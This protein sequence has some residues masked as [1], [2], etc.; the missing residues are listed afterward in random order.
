M[1]D[2]KLDYDVPHPIGRATASRRSLRVAVATGVLLACVATTIPSI[3]AAVPEPAPVVGV[4]GTA[5]PSAAPPEKCGT[6][7]R[8]ETALQG[9]VPWAD[10]LSGRAAEGYNCNLEIVGEFASAS[11]ANFDSYRTCVYYTDNEGG[12]GMAEGGGVVLDVSDPANPVKTDYLTARAMGNGG[13]SLRVNQKRGLL[14]TNHYNTAQ[15]SGDSD[16][17]RALAVYDLKKD[18]RH[19]ELLADVIM[20]A[21]EGHE[22]C[23][24]P[25]GNVYY[26][27]S[28]GTITPIDLTN[29][30]KPRQLSDPW[31]LPIHGCSISDDGKRGYLASMSGTLVAAA[32]A[33]DAAKCPGMLVVDTSA[34]QQLQRNAEFKIISCFATPDAVVQQST[35]PLRYG[36]RPYLFDWSEAVDIPTSPC[37]S[38]T[39]NFGYGWFVDISDEKN[40]YEVSKLQTEVML[41]QH[42]ATVA[43]DR[44]PQ[45]QGHTHGDAFWGFGSIAFTYDMHYCRPDRLHNPTILGCANFGSGL[46]VFDIRNPRAPQE[47]AYYNTGTAGPTHPALDFAVAP[48]VIRRDLGMIFWVTLNG[49][50]HAAK[51]REGVWPFKGDDRCPSSSD[52][53]AKQYDTGFAACRAA[54]ERRGGTA[55]Q[56]KPASAQ[57]SSSADGDS[58]PAQVA[59]PSTRRDSATGAGAA[60]AKPSASVTQDLATTGVGTPLGWLVS[61]ALLMVSAGLLLR[62]RAARAKR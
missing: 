59:A 35:Y 7:D 48:P 25:D 1:L 49:G 54:A 28:I 6:G 11:F 61:T 34:V 30:R 37:P 9:Q 26:M 36:N 18:C 22:G 38:S 51:F 15:T 55:A 56:R 2:D 4:T 44:G 20:P 29:P 47:I 53:F 21:A 27:A 50:F 16:V 41:P 14:V 45:T 42:C 17:V 60:S 31:P 32:G 19:P 23:F 3:S 33:E 40:P 46:R 24:Q 8:P 10:R 12:S 5:A 58:A 62:R 39:T 52:Y 43:A 13:E 57:H